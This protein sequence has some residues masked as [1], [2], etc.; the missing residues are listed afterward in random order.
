MHPYK[1]I[2]DSGSP[3]IHLPWNIGNFRVRQV[4]VNGGRRRAMEVSFRAHHCG[5][6]PGNTGVDVGRGGRYPIVFE[7]VLWI[8]GP[9]GV[10]KNHYLCP[11]CYHLSLVQNGMK[12][13]EGVPTFSAKC[14]RKGCNGT[15]TFT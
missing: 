11:A 5:F 15:S 10:V 3:A 6:V 2:L 1:V 9:E 14:T 12:E 7:R 4:V 13:V 8:E